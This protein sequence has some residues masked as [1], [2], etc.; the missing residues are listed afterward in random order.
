MMDGHGNGQP[1]SP[2]SGKSRNQYA[3]RD[4]E[5]CFFWQL[6]SSDTHDE[7]EEASRTSIGSAIKFSGATMF[8][9]EIWRHF[10]EETVE[11]QSAKL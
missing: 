11:L 1:T 5:F 3:L 8:E 9:F 7:S 10:I 6:T 4:S 2:T